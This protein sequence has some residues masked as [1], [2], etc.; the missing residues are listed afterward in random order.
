MHNI[1]INT[2]K[3][4]REKAGETKQIKKRKKKKQEIVPFMFVDASC[5]P[6][7]YNYRLDLTSVR[8]NAMLYDIGKSETKNR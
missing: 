2:I 5:Y 3:V 8:S 6:L 1:Q 4:K 7:Y